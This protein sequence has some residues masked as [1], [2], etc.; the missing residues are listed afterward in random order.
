VK[1]ADGA[2]NAVRIFIQGLDD[3]T[4]AIALINKKGCCSA[5][6]PRNID[7]LIKVDKGLDV[8]MKFS[9]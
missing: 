4:R 6:S 1:S 9:I 7:L 8:E 2:I 3:N 5:D